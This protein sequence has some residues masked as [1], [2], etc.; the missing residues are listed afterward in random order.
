MIHLCNDVD[1]SS[2]RAGEPKGFEPQSAGVVAVLECRGFMRVGRD[3]KCL[4]KEEFQITMGM[5]N[6]NHRHRRRPRL[7]VSCQDRPEGAGTNNRP[8]GLGFPLWYPLEDCF[9]T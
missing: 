3:W 8:R 4:V 7:P 5:G 2:S 9:R 6:S 1:R